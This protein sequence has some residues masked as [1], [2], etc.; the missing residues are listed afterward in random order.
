M[1]NKLWMWLGGGLVALLAAVGLYVALVIAPAVYI[2]TGYAAHRLCSCVFVSARTEASC[3]VDLGDEAAA[4]PVTVD[5]DRRTVTAR[6]PL[7]AESVA[8]YHG[9]TGC[10]L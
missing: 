5:R 10:R 1:R 8:T 7:L 6:I 2:G 4:I 3:R 9:H